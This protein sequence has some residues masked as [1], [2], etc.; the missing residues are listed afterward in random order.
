MILPLN[1]H[2]D[3]NVSV[4]DNAMS[5][6]QSAYIHF[7]SEMELGGIYNVQK[8]IETDNYVATIVLQKDFTY[9]FITGVA[10]VEYERETI[11]SKEEG[12][13]G[14]ITHPTSEDGPYGWGAPFDTELGTP[15]LSNSRTLLS[16][17]G[18][19]NE[20]DLEIIRGIL[21]TVL[22]GN[23]NWKSGGINYSWHGPLGYN[24]SIPPR[25]NNDPDSDI[26]GWTD[27]IRRTKTYTPSSFLI[28][29]YSRFKNEVYSNGLLYR[30]LPY[31]VLG[32]GIYAGFEIAICQVDETKDN[33]YYYNGTV[34]VLIDEIIYDMPVDR[35]LLGRAGAYWFSDDGT[36]AAALIDIL[37]DDFIGYFSTQ[38]LFGGSNIASFETMVTTLSFSLILGIPSFTTSSTVPNSAVVKRYLYSDGG[39]DTSSESTD[40]YSN[41]VLEKSVI[42]V[43]YNGNDQILINIKWNGENYII[44]KNITTVQ[45]ITQDLEHPFQHNGNTTYDKQTTNTGKVS[46]GLYYN[47]EYSNINVF[48][49]YDTNGSSSESKDKTVVSSQVTAYTGTSNSSISKEWVMGYDLLYSNV[50]WK[51]HIFRHN[52][53]LTYDGIGSTTSSFNSSTADVDVSSTWG[54]K[55]FRNLRVLTEEERALDTEEYDSSYHFIIAGSSNTSFTPNLNNFFAQTT[56]LNQTNFYRVTSGRSA[57]SQY[58]YSPPDFI[59]YP[60]FATGQ[61]DLHGNL[62]ASAWTEVMLNDYSDASIPISVK[63]ERKLNILP[64]DK[65]PEQVIGVTGDNQSLIQNFYPTWSSADVVITKI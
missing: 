54:D 56:P 57:P 21:D 39:T 49:L 63:E 51:R 24:I 27:Y 50:R 26:Q 30:T 37:D 34:W 62:I 6:M 58:L 23:C 12:A 52:R 18:L 2:V 10:A 29:T 28:S 44:N 45:G 1:I 53:Y 3:E 32:F 48:E 17:K 14:I 4:S 20:Q 61:V 38:S 19:N 11:E 41:H 42:G 36:E 55:F 22:V 65:T 8:N 9:G 64:L 47:D 15:S 33:V 46:Y 40:T 43:G 25:Y 35:H 59:D 13:E 7:A 60:A 31:E 5:E 16:Y